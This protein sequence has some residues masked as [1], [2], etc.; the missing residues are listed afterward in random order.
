MPSGIQVLIKTPEAERYKGDCLHP[1]IRFIPEGFAGYKW[2]MV[3][4]PYYRRNSKNENP[5]LYYSEDVSFPINWEYST[6]VQDTPEYG[7]N[8]DPN[9]F[10][11]NGRLWIFWREHKTP[12]CS[13][14]KVI[15]ATFGVYTTDGVTFSNPKAY[16]KQEEEGIDPELCPTLIKFEGKY[17]FYCSNY[18]L[19]GQR[20]NRGIA[21]WEGTNLDKPDFKLTYISNTRKTLTVD[22]FKQI[23]LL[24]HLFF[25]PKPLKHDI[26]HFDLMEYNKKLYML[27]VAEWGDN[28]MLSESEDYLHFRT[29]RKPLLN[30]HYSENK[31]GFRP[32]FYKPTGIILNNSLAIYYTI[33]GK[34]EIKKNNLYRSTIKFN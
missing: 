20:I 26:W 8:S 25:V 9:I 12:R 19:Y 27:S 16:L 29:Y 11:E 2:W 22:K 30:S 10:Y 3:Q 24:N 14:L 31:L 17:R 7:F 23:T 34:N 5:L 21:I 33:S 13:H 6:V 4:S 32:Y 15:S 1:C 28:I 18:Q